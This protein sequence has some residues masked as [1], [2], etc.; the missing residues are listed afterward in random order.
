LLLDGLCTRVPASDSDGAI[1]E[2]VEAMENV[3]A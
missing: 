1:V 3:L 2:V